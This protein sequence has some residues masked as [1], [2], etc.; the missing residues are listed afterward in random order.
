VEGERRVSGGGSPGAAG[1]ALPLTR[2]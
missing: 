1:L 2:A